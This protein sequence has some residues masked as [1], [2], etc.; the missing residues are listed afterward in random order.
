MSA[1]ATDQA[2][3]DELRRLADEYGDLLGPSDLYRRADELDPPH[4]PTLSEALDHAIAAGT[5][6]RTQPC[7]RGCGAPVI[8]C[9]N[10]TWLD[11]EPV[12]RGMFG[13]QQI[14]PMLVAMGGGAI[15]TP[16]MPHDHQPE[17]EA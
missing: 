17:D 6:S 5:R 13:L 10:G 8:V 3:A 4:A 9:D 11:A 15:D 7:P 14:G 12:E 16:Y 1:Q 2:T